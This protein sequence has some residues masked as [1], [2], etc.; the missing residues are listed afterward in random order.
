VDKN[1][2]AVTETGWHRRVRAAFATVFLVASLIGGAEAF[3]PLAEMDD[4]E[5]GPT[6]DAVLAESRA[7]EDD[8]VRVARRQPVSVRRATAFAPRE[9]IPADSQVLS[10]PR[11][12]GKQRATHPTGPPAD[13][14]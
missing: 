7:L 12:S 3:A 4:V 5:N 1:Q 10:L 2:G 8:V 9:S 13:F 11:N 14:A 6:L